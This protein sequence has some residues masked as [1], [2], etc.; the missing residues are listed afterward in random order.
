MWGTT[1]ST[2]IEVTTLTDLMKGSSQVEIQQD[3][4][5]L[6][7]AVF[8]PRVQDSHSRSISSAP[9]SIFYLEDIDLPL[10]ICT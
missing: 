2:K 4:S 5:D 9:N 6:Q 8:F 7:F 1:E 10:L 3:Y